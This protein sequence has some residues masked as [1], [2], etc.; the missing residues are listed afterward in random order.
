MIAE[1]PLEVCHAR[2]L[3]GEP[4]PVPRPLREQNREGL[5]FGHLQYMQEHL[6]ERR[7]PA[8]H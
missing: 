5:S 6:P 3:D 8:G 1:K 2:A 7:R 4:E